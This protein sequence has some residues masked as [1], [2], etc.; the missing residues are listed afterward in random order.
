MKKAIE[1]FKPDI[2]HLNNF[3]RQLSSSIIDAI[4]EKNIPIVFTAHDLQTVCPNKTMLDSQNKICEKCIKGHYYNCI[5]KK[6][7][8]NSSLKSLL[9]AL[10]GRYYKMKKIYTQKIDKIISP[11]Q[12]LIHNF[13]DI[14]QYNVETQDDGYA[15]YFGR[16]SEEK[17]IKNLLKAFAKLENGKL[18]I[19]GQGPEENYIKEFIEKNNLQERIKLLGFLKQDEMIEA[20]RKCKFMVIP[21]VWYDNC[22]YSIIETLIIGKPVIGSKMG[23]I[24]ELVKDNENGF[25]FEYND[26]ESLAQKMKELFDDEELVK[27]F[28]ENAKES[29]IKLYSKEAYY[30]KIIEVYNELIKGAQN[31]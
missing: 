16:L 24:P 4:K 22:P 13:L 28:S 30:D 12:F 17:G 23:G 10:E 14:N 15:L 27:R 6:C 18:Y 8:K 11:S 19:A 7:V 29:S 26:I 20:V 1:D 9:G 5:K 3:Q 31:G 2:V 25:I 21:S